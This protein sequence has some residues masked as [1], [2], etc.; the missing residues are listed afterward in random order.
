[1]NLRNL[2]QCELWKPVG[3]FEEFYDVSNHG[4]LRSYHSG[5][6][7]GP[8]RMIPRVLRLCRR[9]GQYTQFTLKSPETV[10]HVRIHELV[11]KA[12]V[13]K[14]PFPGVMEPNHL[15]GDKADNHVVNLEWTTRSENVTHAFDL[16]LNR[17]GEQHPNAVLTADEVRTIR[18]LRAWGYSQNDIAA[19][20]GTTQSR[21]SLITRNK[22]WKRT[23]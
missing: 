13:E 22:A 9:S 20:F 7:K 23:L 11:A 19:D 5:N 17:H 6:G 16:G 10:D 18:T 1:M 4:R 15:N 3:G 14:P 12:F 21:V 8:R 2:F